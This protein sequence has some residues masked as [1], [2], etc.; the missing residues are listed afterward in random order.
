MLRKNY[1]V[2]L[3]GPWLLVCPMSH[4]WCCH[5]SNTAHFFRC[6]KVHV[7]CFVTILHFLFYLHHLR[8][9]A[10]IRFMPCTPEDYCHCA[11]AG[12]KKKLEKSKVVCATSIAPQGQKGQR[13]AKN[14]RHKIQNIHSARIQHHQQVQKQHSGS[15]TQ[16]SG[17]EKE[18]TTM[19]R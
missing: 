6:L 11:G 10:Q 18:V 3:G 16:H 7:H 12:C 9:S 4:C 5:T 17:S 2:S 19:T 13:R 8:D 1:N 15:G 14:K